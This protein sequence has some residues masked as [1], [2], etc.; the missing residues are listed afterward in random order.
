MQWLPVYAKSMAL[1]QYCL[2]DSRN[3]FGDDLFGF[4]DLFDRR[5]SAFWD[6]HD[7]EKRVWNQPNNI[8]KGK[9]THVVNAM[10]LEIAAL[11]P[12][13][14]RNWN[15]WNGALNC[16]MKVSN[17][18]WS[19]RHDSDTIGLDIS[20]AYCYFKNNFTRTKKK[21]GSSSYELVFDFK[22]HWALTGAPR[23]PSTFLEFRLSF[24]PIHLHK[25]FSCIDRNMLRHYRPEI[26]C[27]ENFFRSQKLYHPSLSHS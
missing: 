11:S 27:Q 5:V 10:F 16:C 23:L 13:I 18:R 22:S 24:L 19:E 14:H 2:L 9:V 3:P 25:F 15:S 4:C 21:E 17:L 6:V 20:M 12:V 1:D 8:T 7:V 26:L